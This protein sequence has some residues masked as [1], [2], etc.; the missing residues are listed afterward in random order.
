MRVGARLRLDLENAGRSAQV[1]RSRS[2]GFALQV[3]VM[4]KAATARA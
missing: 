4:L 1:L 3:A 2:N